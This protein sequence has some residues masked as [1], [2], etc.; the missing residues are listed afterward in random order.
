MNEPTAA[1][2][3]PDRTPS[4]ASTR[5]LAARVERCERELREAISDLGTAIESAVDWRRVVADHPVGSALAIAALGFAVGY[6]PGLVARTGEVALRSLAELG[7]DALARALAP[8]A[9]S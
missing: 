2:H 6:R 3:A 7:T 4:L 1:A 9:R 5:E 8:D